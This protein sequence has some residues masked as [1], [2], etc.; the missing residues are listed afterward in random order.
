MI[1]AELAV[2]LHE[3]I[4]HLAGD[5]STLGELAGAVERL[6][7]TVNE[8]HAALGIGAIAERRNR[9]AGDTEIEAELES[10]RAEVQTLGRVLNSRTEHLA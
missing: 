5:S 3:L 7:R 8:R 6:E 1:P 2:A 10:L 9:I 4:D